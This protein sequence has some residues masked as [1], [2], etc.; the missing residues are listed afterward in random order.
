MPLDSDETVWGRRWDGHSAMVLVDGCVY[1]LSVAVGLYQD[2][3]RSNVS[4]R[5]QKNCSYTS[6]KQAYEVIL[7]WRYEET[8]PFEAS[9]DGQNE[10]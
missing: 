4:T 2:C 8:G 1:L 5:I 3:T 7:Y 10:Q 9:V 6:C